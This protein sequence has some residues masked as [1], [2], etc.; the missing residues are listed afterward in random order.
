MKCLGQIIPRLKYKIGTVES[1]TIK[2]H[3]IPCFTIY[4]LLLTLKHLFLN[5]NIPPT[6][7]L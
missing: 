4:W 2:P 1:D 7:T 3:S 6:V 5:Y